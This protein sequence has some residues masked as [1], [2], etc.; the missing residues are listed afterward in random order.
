MLEKIVGFVCSSRRRAEDGFNT[1]VYRTPS[2][3]CRRGR[4]DPVFVVNSTGF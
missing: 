1:L 2:R 4:V 3:F